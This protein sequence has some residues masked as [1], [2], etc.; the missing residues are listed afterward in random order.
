MSEETQGIFPKFRRANIQK[1]TGAE[2]LYS[3]LLPCD[4]FRR[5]HTANGRERQFHPYRIDDKILFRRAGHSLLFRV[6]PY[7]HARQVQ[8]AVGQKPHLLEIE[9]ASEMLNIIY[10]NRVFDFDDTIL[11]SEIHDG[12]MR[13]YMAAGN[14]DLTSMLATISPVVKKRINTLNNGFGKQ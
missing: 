5:T 12:K 14:R 8:P 2:G 1:C 7:I 9:E 4:L 3:L 10:A 6:F 11:C 13:E